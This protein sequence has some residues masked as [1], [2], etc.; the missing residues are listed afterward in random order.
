LEVIG[1]EKIGNPRGFAK[2]PGKHASVAVEA[3]GNSWMFCQTL[4]ERV[5]RLVV[6]NPNQFKVISHSV[7]KTDKND[8]KVLA[9]FFEKTCL[10]RGE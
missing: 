10:R 5:G 8:A 9:E 3:T 2:R 1:K 7:K 4:K 6:V